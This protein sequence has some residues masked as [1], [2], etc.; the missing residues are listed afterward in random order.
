MSHLP[1][2]ISPAAY[3]RTQTMDIRSAMAR[4]LAVKLT[5]AEYPAPDGRVLKFAEVFDTWPD[6]EDAYRPPGTAAILPAAYPMEPSQLTPTLLEETWEPAGQAGFGLYKTAE[7]M[8]D[9]EI[10]I[11]AST[12]AERRVFLTG[13]ESMWVAEHVLM[14]PVQGARYGILLPMPEYWGTC[15]EFA[16]KTIRV[17]DDEDRA[18]RE[19]REAI[20]TVS[21]LAAMVK[22]GPVQP[23]KMSIRVSVDTCP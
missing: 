14:D 2:I 5:A 21:G 11:R 4:A 23:M 15:A 3:S 8:A 13:I 20:I 12:A 9:F 22:L 16:L 6:P 1:T 19:H 7:V 10:L 18:M 17:L